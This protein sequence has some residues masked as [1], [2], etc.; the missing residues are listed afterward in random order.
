MPQT[1]H[2][3]SVIYTF[4]ACSMLRKADPSTNL[5]TARFM[6]P[7]IVGTLPGAIAPLYSRDRAGWPGSL[8]KI[9]ASVAIGTQSGIRLHERVPMVKICGSTK[10]DQNQTTGK[11]L[12]L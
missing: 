8:P 3:Q 9:C 4:W 1:I 12:K 6:L 2:K 11:L 10:N 5:G 7:V